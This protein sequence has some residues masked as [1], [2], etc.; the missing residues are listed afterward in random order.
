MAKKKSNT[1]YLSDN[2]LYKMYKIHKDAGSTW[3][4]MVNL[5]D[6]ADYATKLKR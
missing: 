2:F 6:P 1:H 3:F 5:E 4:G